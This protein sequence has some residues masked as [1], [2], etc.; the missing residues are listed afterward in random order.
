MKFPT[1]LLKII[2]VSFHKIQPKITNILINKVITYLNT[3]TTSSKRSKIS[4]R[5]YYFLNRLLGNYKYYSPDTL[6]VKII[7]KKMTSLKE[8][9]YFDIGG[10]EGLYFDLLNKNIRDIQ[11]AY[12]FE[13][14]E[15][16]YKILKYKYKSFDNVK[17]VNTGFSTRNQKVKIY[18]KFPGSQE[19][20]IHDPDKEF[21][22]PYEQMVSFERLDEYY[23]K[24]LHEKKI[25]YLNINN[26]EESL[27]ILLSGE[28]VLKN[29]K[30]I[31][32]TIKQ[33]L[34][35]ENTNLDK[36]INL[37]NSNNFEL[38]KFSE[39]GLLEIDIK[40]KLKPIKNNFYFKFVAIQR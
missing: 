2:I 31:T 18:S 27:E 26:K 8:I 40:N 30:I 20:E 38:F 3:K 24:N 21:L 29:F 14:D 10:E 25:D 28:S 9:K 22:S 37:L 5:L 32:F 15:I 23:L 4:S 1:N 6:L 11:E 39:L 35:D 16:N 36:C 17:V 12:L 19:Y 33:I 13:L 7:S 34:G